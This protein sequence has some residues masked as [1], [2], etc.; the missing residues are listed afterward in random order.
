MSP[1]NSTGNIRQQDA[2]S[3]NIARNQISQALAL[4]SQQTRVLVSSLI[5]KILE[6]EAD[7]RPVDDLWQ[8]IQNSRQ[9]TP[10][11]SKAD[12]N[13]ADYPEFSTWISG[14][15]NAIARSQKKRIEE[16]VGPLENQRRF[17]NTKGLH[18]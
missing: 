9:L 1:F 12:N 8:D 10:I 16:I 11:K 2:Q 13:A 14:Q 18:G 7:V 15:R 6:K 3:R 5:G 4:E 17:A